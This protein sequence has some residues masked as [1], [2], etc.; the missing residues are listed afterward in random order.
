MLSLA[1]V[2]K[3]VTL[4]RCHINDTA[5]CILS[6]MPAVQSIYMTM[7]EYGSGIA[8]ASSVRRF[9]DVEAGPPSIACADYRWC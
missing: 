9:P 7:V 1:P 5:H 2:V 4:L 6:R 3:A 8:L